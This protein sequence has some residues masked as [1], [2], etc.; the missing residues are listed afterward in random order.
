MK[1]GLGSWR[2]FLALL[3]AISHLWAG[4]IDGPAAYAVWGFFVL[5]GY[6]MTLVLTIKYGIAP[7]GLGRFAF[8]RL[9][10]IYPSFIV[11]GVFG[12]V[13]ILVLRR[14]GVDPTILNPQFML[15][16]SGQ[17]WV[18]NLAMVPFVSQQGLP[19]PVS[20]ALFVEVWAYALMPLFAQSKAAA[21]LGLAVASFANL[22]FGFGMPT[23][24]ARYCGFAT[25]LMPFALGAVVCHYRGS[26]RRFAHPILSVLIWCA[27]GCYW[28]VNV[29][30]PWTYGLW[31]S[32]PLSAWVV[33][34]LAEIRS[35]PADNI[36]G[37]LSYPV[38]L[39]HTTM[40][41]WFLPVFGFGRSFMFF[42]A[43]FAVTLLAAWGMLVMIDRPMQRLRRSTQTV[44][45]TARGPDGIYARSTGRFTG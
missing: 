18:G 6:L 4:M 28:L 42:A 29:Y 41:A 30:W 16:Q 13:T 35:S 34:S 31:L 19:V 39:L 45:G 9:L 33:L 37:E 26:L 27:H 23:F 36:A 44:P 24:V 11:A 7:C 8:N 43:S 40:A 12:I 2:L 17:E 1:I 10:R 20:A 3:V 15:P 21:M 32:V 22:Q 5:S 38:Y 14:I 25:G